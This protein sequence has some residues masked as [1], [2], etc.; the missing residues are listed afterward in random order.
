MT[1]PARV[2]PCGHVKNESRVLSIPKV[3]LPILGL[4]LVGDA[5]GH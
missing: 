5:A 2:V 3:S 4:F 1:C